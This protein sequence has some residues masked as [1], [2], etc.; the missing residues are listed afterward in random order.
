MITDLTGISITVWS[1]SG[2]IGV[3]VF[4]PNGYCDKFGMTWRDELV[5]NAALLDA[6]ASA[7]QWRNSCMLPSAFGFDYYNE[8]KERWYKVYDGE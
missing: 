4:A 6:L 2:K 1:R 5:D 3:R 8:D 7:S